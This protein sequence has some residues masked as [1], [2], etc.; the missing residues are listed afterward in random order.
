MSNGYQEARQRG[1]GA[2]PAKREGAGAGARAAEIPAS[3]APGGQAGSDPRARAAALQAVRNLIMAKPGQK[4][5]QLG[6][7]RRFLTGK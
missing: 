6:A 5:K 1:A 4:R 3:G 2:Q 7:V